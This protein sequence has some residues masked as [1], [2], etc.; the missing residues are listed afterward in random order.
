MYNFENS[1]FYFR[2][3]IINL[4]IFSIN[5]KLINC[6]TRKILVINDDWNS[7]N[8]KNHTV[9]SPILFS[10]TSFKAM[11]KT[12]FNGIDKFVIEKFNFAEDVRTWA[13]REIEKLKLKD[14]RAI[15]YEITEQRNKMIRNWIEY[16]TV[17]NVANR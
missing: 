2:Y 16:V 6:Q 17:E 9:L 14:I 5:Y 15:H 4:K 11:K 13:K 8:P 3:F 7:F 1:K 10:P 12:Q